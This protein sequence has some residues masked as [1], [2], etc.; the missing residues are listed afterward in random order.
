MPLNHR[1]KNALLKCR[2]QSLAPDIAA[3]FDDLLRLHELAERVDNPVGN[4]PAAAVMDLPVL[5]HGV[6]L[7]RMTIGAH[8]WLTEGPLLW[9][10][11]SVYKA[12]MCVAYALAHSRQPETLVAMTDPRATWKTVKAWAK[13]VGASYGELMAGCEAALGDSD[14]DSDGSGVPDYAAV[15]STCMREYGN[16]PDFWKWEA[17]AEFVSAMIDEHATRERLQF[18]REQARLGQAVPPGPN[19]YGVKEM[20]EFQNCRSE[21]FVKLQARLS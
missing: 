19:D 3:D 10:K 7:R 13:T 17:S 12:D 15:L 14:E 4:V 11:R 8:Y 16:T 1:V 9:F 6:S 21:Y 20:R 5:V 2:A 18:R